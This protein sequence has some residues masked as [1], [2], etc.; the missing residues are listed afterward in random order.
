MYSIIDRCRICSSRAL[1]PV[2]DLGVQSLT[3]VFPRSLDERVSAGPLELV[4]C[5]REGACGLV[6]LRESFDPEE[7][8]GQ[9]YGYRSSLNS[10]MVAH[11]QEIVDAVCRRRPL[12]PGDLV[13][14][15]GSND[16]TLLQRY[17]RKDLN[18]LGVD[19]TGRKFK[20]FYPPW[21]KL[22]P[23]FFSSKV[24]F[25]AVGGKKAK[26]IT[27]IAMLYDLERPLDF[28]AEVRDV[29]DDEGLWVFEQSYMPSMLR[30]T[31]YDT[32]CHEHLEY[33]SLAQIRH[34]T[35]KTGFKIVAVELNAVNGGS[36]C[37]TVAKT[38][39]RHQ[40]DRGAIEALMKS[41]QEEA[42]STLRPYA[43]FRSRVFRHRDAL[44]ELLCSLKE[45]GEQ[46]LGY[47]AS[48]KGN[49]ILQFCGI[50]PELLPAIAEVNPD[51]FGRLTPGS[52]IP[53][54]SEEEA[55]LRGPDGFLVLPWH[56]RENILAREASY[57]RSGG[58][59][60]FPLPSIDTVVG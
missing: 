11:L 43:A 60:I 31:A 26:I 17:A 57:L 15:I 33:Y 25:G 35:E 24:V 4:K 9:N 45:K 8:Y 30:M 1:E 36:F 21:V 27:S 55:K 50:G 22:V 49:V 29:L 10:S 37:V 32:V 39:S 48:T 23:D 16:S 19:P 44:L 2:L 56:F 41:E 13:I 34:M 54:I 51:K 46:I 59:L 18:L 28:F 5:S 40:E 42:L 58:R 6:Q 20:E 3:G 12:S 38:G 53:I 47:G 14:D 7:M 52:G